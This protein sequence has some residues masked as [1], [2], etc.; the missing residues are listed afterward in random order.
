MKSSTYGGFVSGRNAEDI[1]FTSNIGLEILP[2]QIERY[3]PETGELT[4]WG[5]FKTL[6]K[7]EN[8][9]YLYYGKSDA[10]MQSSIATF[11]KFFRTV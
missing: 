2:F 10:V 5:S 9:C 11:D 1:V 7:Q 3:N 4:A 6:S 8:E